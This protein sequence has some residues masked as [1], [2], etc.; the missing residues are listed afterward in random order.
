MTLT[1][2]YDRDGVALYCGDCREVL[3]EEMRT[4]S[5]DVVPQQGAGVPGQA[6]YKARDALVLARRAMAGYCRYWR[7][8]I[9]QEPPQSRRGLICRLPRQVWKGRTVFQIR[10][11]ACRRHEWHDEHLLWRVM[12]L[13]CFG[14]R[15]CTLYGV[16]ETARAG[17]Q[18]PLFTGDAA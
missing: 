13:D 18:V 4:V 7:D 15:S 11:A 12:S 16:S 10:C 6:G 9:T 8:G 17:G 3:A 1:P 14:C 5:D 2:D